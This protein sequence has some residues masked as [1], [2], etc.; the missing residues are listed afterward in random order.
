MS[1]A[2]SADNRLSAGRVQAA[3]TVDP[4]FRLPARP[5]MLPGL[6]QVPTAS[7]RAVVTASGIESF[8]G[9]ASQEFLPSVM[10]LLDGHRDLRV[11]ATELGASVTQVH[12][13]ASLLYMRGLV[14][15]G[16]DP[17]PARDPLSLWLTRGIDGTRLHRSGHAAQKALRNT[18]VAVIG[19]PHLAHR[20]CELLVEDGVNASWAEPAADLAELDRTARAADFL[21]GAADSVDPPAWQFALDAWVRRNGRAWLR[22]AVTADRLHVGPRLDARVETSLRSW[23]PL[24]RPDPAASAPTHERTELALCHVACEVVCLLAGIGEP[25]TGNGVQDV[26]LVTLQTSQLA[27]GRAPTTTS[28]GAACVAVSFDEMVRFPPKELAY[29][30]AHLSHYVPANGLKQFQRKTYDGRRELDLPPGTAESLLAS[31]GRDLGPTG[32]SGIALLLRTAFGLQPDG[33]NRGDGHVH[34]YHATGGNLGS[35]Q[36]Y[37][38]ALDIAGLPSGW[39]YYDAF[40]HRLVAA[41]PATPEQTLRELA[42]GAAALIVSTAAYE[43]V[44]GKYGPFSVRIMNMDAGVSLHQLGETALLLGLR[45]QRVGGVRFADVAGLLSIDPASEPVTE[46][47]RLDSGPA[48]LPPASDDRPA[49]ATFGSQLGSPASRAL[50]DR[51]DVTTELLHELAD[52]PTPVYD[53]G[54]L[55]GGLLGGG[56]WSAA[57]YVRALA[58]RRSGREYSSEPLPAARLAAFITRGLYAAGGGTPVPGVEAVVL[59]LR[60]T[61]RPPGFYRLGL[62]GRYHLRAELPPGFDPKQTVLQAE[63]ADAAAI[64]VITGPG[65]AAVY[66]HGGHGYRLL[67]QA[68][69]AVVNEVWL[70]ALAAGL[71]ICGFAGLLPD[72]LA[73]YGGV[74]LNTQTPLFALAI[75]HSRPRA[76]VAHQ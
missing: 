67:L 14:E 17:A 55:G 37:I 73:S 4:Q 69:S 40:T 18:R 25:T 36:A 68:G 45:A 70:S 34:R 65:P 2:T 13:V 64:A 56:R 26:D 30:K 19:P 27:F 54:L 62:D 11:V 75:G 49:A 38:A 43:R 72:V 20:L 71:E 66:Q 10:A 52:R 74:D 41:A 28:D 29:P 9:A 51:M 46:V 16:D 15:D 1:P 60:M 7:G 61:G 39:W 58:G 35:P 8:S 32:L 48:G 59:A 3:V 57:E 63:F 47:V 50:G 24:E 23:W 33:A 21:V 44:S 12:A 5:R 22:C 76:V 6:F 31:S 53:R 42:P